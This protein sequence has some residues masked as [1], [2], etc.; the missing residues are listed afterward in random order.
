VAA[1]AGT[2]AGNAPLPVQGIK[3]VLRMTWDADLG[4]VMEK[5]VEGMLACLVS[6]DLREGT[7]AFLQKRR[8]VYR[9]R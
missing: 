8:P 2:L 4:T 7:S 6:E 1:L 5:E 9:G 3:E